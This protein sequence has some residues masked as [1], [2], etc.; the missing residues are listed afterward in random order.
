MPMNINHDQTNMV[1]LENFHKASYVSCSSDGQQGVSSLHSLAENSC[2]MAQLQHMPMNEI[3]GQ[4]N[5]SYPTNY[6]QYSYP[7]P[8]IVE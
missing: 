8:H 6:S 3:I 4:F 2:Y 1:N 5:S 7:I